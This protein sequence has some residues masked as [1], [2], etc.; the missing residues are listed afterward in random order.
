M[1]EQPFDC[2]CNACT[3]EHTVLPGPRAGHS[4]NRDFVSPMYDSRVRACTG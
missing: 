4:A 3:V 1:G 2:E